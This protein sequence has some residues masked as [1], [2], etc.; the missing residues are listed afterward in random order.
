MWLAA[1]E[2]SLPPA[3]WSRCVQRPDGHVSS[4]LP[5]DTTGPCCRGHFRQAPPQVH[6]GPRQIPSHRPGP[7]MGN[8]QVPAAH[9]AGRQSSRTTFQPECAAKPVPRS[10]SFQR[11]KLRKG[12]DHPHPHSFGA[13]LPT[14][15]LR[16][17]KAAEITGSRP[18]ICPSK[19]TGLLGVEHAAALS[20]SDTQTSKPPDRY[21]PVGGFSAFR[22]CA[23][24]C[25]AAR[26]NARRSGPRGI[27]SHTSESKI[28]AQQ[29]APSRS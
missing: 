9:P 1:V 21:Q 7:P 20:W 26:N 22:A 18:R 17:S 19:G 5:L 23:S 8:G 16:A 24:A 2:V 15:R 4:D 28:T 12:A 6:F 27:T 25:S 3:P 11:G 29:S 10:A 13:R 14:R